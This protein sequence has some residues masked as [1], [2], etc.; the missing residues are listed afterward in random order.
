MATTTKR[1]TAGR[2]APAVIKPRRPLTVDCHAHIVVPEVFEITAKHGLHARLGLKGRTSLGPARESRITMAKMVGTKERLADMDRMGIDIQVISPSIVHQSTYWADGPRA[3]EIDRMTNDGT[4]EMVASHPDRL[5][6]LGLVPLHD[7]AR[8][9]REMTRCVTRLGLRGVAVSTIV[10]GMEIGDRK[11]RPFWRAAEKLDCPVFI[12][13]A[14]NSDKRL[15]KFGLAFNLG[16][17]YEE[18]LAM[19]SLVYEGIM[20]RFPKLKVMIVH[21]GG[22]LPYYAGRQDS[23]SRTGRDGAGLNGEFS[24]YIRK[25]Y[26]DTVLF[27]PDMLEFLT[28]KAPAGHIMMGTD[29]PFGERRPVSFV[30]RAKR[31]SK[32]AQDGILGR[33]AAR[34][35]NIQA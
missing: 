34:L 19:S 11:F 5:V 26:Y 29:Y 2:K 1:G 16:Q 18:A 6:G 12:H 21:G 14:G 27:N 3:L 4:A 13:P 22:F 31:L 9:V 7:P 35:F 20:D 32:A 15:Q 24:S 17:P 10:N 8:A 30:R 23:A 28:T 25:F 33:N